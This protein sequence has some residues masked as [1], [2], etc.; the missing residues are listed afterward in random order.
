MQVWRIG[1]HIGKARLL[2]NAD[3]SRPQD[4]AGRCV[5]TELMPD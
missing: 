1:R 4:G 5:A 3:G 2:E